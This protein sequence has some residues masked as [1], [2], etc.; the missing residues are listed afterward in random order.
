MKSRLSTIVSFALLTLSLL[1]VPAA[2]QEEVKLMG[3]RIVGGEPTDI[4]DHPWQVALNI[5]IGNDTYLCGGSLIQDRWVLTAAHCF[6]PSTTARNVRMKTGVTDYVVSGDWTEIERIIIHEEY[7]PKTHENDIALVRFRARPQGKI[8][9]LAKSEEALQPGTPLEVTGW[10]ATS[11][12][13]KTSR[14][15][16]KATV[17]Y[18]AN[19]ACNAPAAYN[20]A[21]RNGMICAGHREG[22]T[23]SCQG[24]SGGPLVLQSAEGPVLIGVVSWGE[25]CA[26]QLRWG[27]YTRVSSY[28]AWIESKTA[29]VR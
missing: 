9:A 17:P 10:G 15:L 26:R 13:G 8:I 1:Y 11:E 19:E 18:A 27:V 29:S 28:W 5:K 20:G 24:D 3:R 16:R 14:T 7:R 12:G 23:D 21:V 22:G 4:K 25:G 2:G 6:S